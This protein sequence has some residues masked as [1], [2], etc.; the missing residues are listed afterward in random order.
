MTNEDK[1]S[2]GYCVKLPCKVGDVVWFCKLLLISLV[3]KT[4]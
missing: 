4:F 2:Y 3:K 1:L